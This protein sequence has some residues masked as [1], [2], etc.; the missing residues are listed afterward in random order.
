[1]KNT[2]RLIVPVKDLSNIFR[3]GRGGIESFLRKEKVSKC[4][5]KS[6]LKMEEA[7]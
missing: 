2:A 4:S 6:M 3:R 7:P 1:V 5:K